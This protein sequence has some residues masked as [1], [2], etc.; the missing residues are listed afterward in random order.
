[1]YEAVHKYTIFHMFR[2]ANYSMIL[3]S[4]IASGHGVDE[5]SKEMRAL[6][7]DVCQ[8]TDAAPVV[9]SHSSIQII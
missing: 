4:T 8:D 6:N 2:S 9:H 3:H 5:E 1:M 7:S